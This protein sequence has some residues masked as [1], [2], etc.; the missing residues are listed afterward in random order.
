MLKGVGGTVLDHSRKTLELRKATSQSVGSWRGYSPLV[1]GLLVVMLAGCSHTTAHPDTSGPALHGNVVVIG[2]SLSTGFGTSP[3]DAWPLLINT[4]TQESGKTANMVNAA[5]NGSG[6]VSVG[7]N[8]ST[9]GS[10]VTQTVAADTQLVLFFGSGNDVGVE[11]SEIAAAATSAY[12]GAK[13]QAP[14]AEILVVG[15]PSYADE[16]DA[17]TLAVR[18]ALK[19]AATTAGVAF[20]DPIS[21]GWF[22]SHTAE[23][24][25]PDGVHLTVAGGHYVA[26]KME[27]LMKNEMN[28]R[29]A[30]SVSASIPAA[31]RK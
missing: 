20:V 16:P 21:A 29:S 28:Q 3:E 5:E 31:S 26:G 18:D 4:G 13:A 8:S 12:A 11:A 2:D 27:Q 9:F 10:Q 1:A 30:P 15:P 7:E 24:V 14:H 25:G 19:D 17:G 6:Y 23:L 22:R